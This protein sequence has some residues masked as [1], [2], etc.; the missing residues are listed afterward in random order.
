MTLSGPRTIVY[1]DGFNLY[2]GALKGTAN[3]WLNIY[4]MSQLALK[5]HNICKLKYFTAL[6]K[7]RPGDSSQHIRQQV[8]LRALRT[9]PQVEICLG[10]FLVSYPKMVVHPVS[11]PPEFVTVVKTEEK[12]S[13]VNIATHLLMDAYENQFDV[14]VLITNDSDLLMPVQ[15]VRRKLGKRVGI[16]NPQI[17]NPKAKPSWA[18]QRNADFFR[19][20]RKGVL[21]AS[22]FPPTLSDADGTFHKPLSW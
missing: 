6:V 13:D 15:V 7:P 16:L 18:L 22:Q 9:V 20:L 5:G 10:T 2:Y 3:R 21:A 8:Y 17:L 19:T 11:S 12:G 1:V 14:A 4:R